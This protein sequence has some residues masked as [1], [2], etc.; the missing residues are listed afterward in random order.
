MQTARALVSLIAALALAVALGACG[1]NDSLSQ[2]DREK[3]S[4]AALDYVGG[5]TVTD[6]ERGDGDDDYAYEVEVTLSN[7]TEIDVDL[8]DDFKVINNPPK[9]ADFAG[10]A[11]P[12]APTGSAG[13]PSDDAPL[14]GETL[15]RASEAAL[16]AAGGGRVIEATTSDDPDYAYEVEVLLPTD[17]QVTVELDSSFKVVELDP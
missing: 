6:V 4:K 9:A 12:T 7:G 14:T 3:A 1:T 11:T 17:E 5:G 13:T 16:K 2:G 8:D 10:T 15:A